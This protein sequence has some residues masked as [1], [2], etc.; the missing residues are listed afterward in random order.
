MRRRSLKKM[1]GKG[2][3]WVTIYTPVDVGLEIISSWTRLHTVTYA[4]LPD[5]NLCHVH[6]VKDIILPD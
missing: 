5:G 3:S 1:L 6:R 2:Y 4:K